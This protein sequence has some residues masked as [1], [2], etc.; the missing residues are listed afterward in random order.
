[1]KTK[2]LIGLVVLTW[3][4]GAP[5]PTTAQEVAAEVR[6]WA[7]ESWR[8]SQPSLEVFYTIAAEPEEGPAAEGETLRMSVQEFAAR[9]EL[10]RRTARALEQPPALQ[11]HRQTDVVTLSR[12]G[13]E[14]QIPLARI[15]SLQFFRQPVEKSPLPPYVA[16]THYRTAATAVLVDGSRVE[17]DYV[18]LGTTLL[19][20]MTP[21]GRVDIPWQEIE[22]VRFALA[23]ARILPE[24]VKE[25]SPLQDV[26]FDFDRSALR[27]DAKAVLSQ[28][29][30]WLK[31]NPEARIVVEGHCDERG[32]N[33][34]N[35]ALG[36]RRA[37]AVRDYLVA[38]GID[39]G[40]ISTI[41]YGE[42][43]PFVL[44]HD[45]SAWK[46]NRRAHF[47]LSK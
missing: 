24:T 8:L 13:V 45:E 27:K 6:T 42:E 39:P 11:G 20:G 37:A 30:E 40:R 33:E 2:V 5:A 18:N 38:A 16:S 7:G 29:V 17:A 3:L 26:F 9:G 23:E 14:T 36:E 4:L 1:M 31:G 41:S 12:R 22:N 15:R 21:E 44:G 19:R 47:L 34:Y 35:L 25:V 46:W 28:N 32:T 10:E 43:R